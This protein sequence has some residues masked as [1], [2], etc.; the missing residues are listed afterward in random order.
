MITSDIH[1]HSSFSSDSEAPME[2]MILGS[3]AKGLKT[4]CFTEHLDFEYPSD[5]NEVLF[6]VD[7]DAYTKKLFELK[8][9][10][11]DVIEVLYGIEF[12][13]IPHLADPVQGGSKGSRL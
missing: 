5:N 12:G 10:Y 2:S 13:L 1:M 9:K 6:Q 3:A 8:N 11:K 7:F 4:I